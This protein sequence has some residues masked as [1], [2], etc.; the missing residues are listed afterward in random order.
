MYQAKN[1]KWKQQMMEGIE[2][3]NQKK[4]QNTWKKGNLQKLGNIGSRHHEICED[5][6]KNK[7]RILQEKEKTT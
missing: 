4:N 3:L 6:R 5:E 2:L 7:K 1:K